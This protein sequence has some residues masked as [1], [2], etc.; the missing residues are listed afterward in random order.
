MHPSLVGPIM[1]THLK[2]KESPWQ[3][4]NSFAGGGGVTRA[5][6]NGGGGG[7]G[8]KRGSRDCAVLRRGTLVVGLPLTIPASYPILPLASLVENA[9]PPPLSL[10]TRSGLENEYAMNPFH[11]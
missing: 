9:T 6:Q 2:I 3:M 7:V 5:P 11:V 4:K 1:A 8:G 10:P